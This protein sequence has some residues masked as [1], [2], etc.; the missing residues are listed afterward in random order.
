MLEEFYVYYVKEIRETV[1]GYNFIDHDN[2]PYYTDVVRWAYDKFHE[3]KNP[4]DYKTNLEYL[5][6]ELA[7]D[8]KITKQIQK[9]IKVV[10]FKMAKQEVSSF[11][12]MNKDSEIPED[13][14][15]LFQSIEK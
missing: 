1:K 12:E 15:P 11:N 5:E 14:K 6:A 4:E 10:A 8:V 13:L 2:L 9:R 7:V 3:F